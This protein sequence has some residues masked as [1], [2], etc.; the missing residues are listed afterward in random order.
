MCVLLLS[1][2]KKRKR[3]IRSEHLEMLFPGLQLL[4]TNFFKNHL[5]VKTGGKITNSKLWAPYI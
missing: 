4:L 3:K 2:I 5:L 1:D